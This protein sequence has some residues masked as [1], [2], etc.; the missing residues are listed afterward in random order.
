MKTPPFILAVSCAVFCSHALAQ[1]KPKQP[2]NYGLAQARESVGKMKV[3]DGLSVGLFAAEPMVQNPTA[4][5]IDSRGRV[6]LTEAANYR[7]HANPPIRPEGDRVMTLEDTNGDGEADK[8]TVFY[9][10]PSIN[11]ALGIAVL[12]NDV[13]VSVAP[14]VFVL[15]DTDGD[16]VA[17]QRLL[18]LTGTAGAQHDHSFHSFVHGTD[19]KLYFNFGNTGQH[20]RQ[21]AGKLLKVPL[22]GVI[23]PADVKD[24][25]APIIDLAGN[26]LE[27]SRKP[28]QQ[29]MVFRA[30]YA[31]GRLSN[32]EVLGYNFRNNYEAAPDSFGNL[33]QSDNDDDGNRGVRINYVMEH[34]SYGYSDELTGAAWQTKRPNIEKEIPLRHWHQNDPGTVPNLLQTGA[35]SPTGLLCNEGSALGAKFTNQIIHCDAGPRVVRAYPVQKAGAGFSAE[36][37]DILTSSDNWFRPSDVAIHPDG[38]LFVADWYDAGVGGH[39]M[40]DNEAPFLRGRIYRVSAKTGG[41]SV[42]KLDL[43]SAVGAV[44]ALQSPN[45]ATQFVAYRALSALGDA[46]LPA[47]QTLAE[48]G[49]PRLRAR[50]LA[51]LARSPKA[52]LPAL[53]AALTDANPDIVITAIRLATMLATAG[54]LDTSTLEAT[55]GLI[56]RLIGHKDPQVR[57]QLA[58]SLFHSK[59]VEPMWAKLAAQHDGSDRWYLE[60]LG[61]GARG[62]DDSCFDAWF[63]EVK[64]NW[65]TPGGRDILWR[66]RTPKTAPYLASLLLANPTE[67]RY[68]RAFDFIPESQ[69]RSDALLSLVK[70]NPGLAIVSEALQRLS[71]SGAKD[72]PRVRTATDAAL[73]RAKGRPEF[74][75]LVEAAGLGSWGGALLETA[76]ELGKAPEALD[77]VRLLVREGAGASQIQEALAKGDPARSAALVELLGSLGQGKA[78]EML[79]AELLQSKSAERGTLAI[80]A[81]A[82]TQNGAERLVKLAKEKRFPAELQSVA[83]SALAQVQYAALRE[84]IGLHFPPPGALGGAALPPVAELAKLS[85]D[86]ARGKGVFERASSSCVVCHKIGERGVD[87]G[88]ALG[89]I[90]GKLPKEAIF[91]AILNPN[92]GISMGFETAEVKLRGGGQALGIVRSDTSEEL[93]LAL[94]G[95][96]LQ[97]FAK[98]DVQR[99]SKLPT[100]LMP[101]GLNQALTREDLVDLVAYL[102]N[103]KAGSPK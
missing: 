89:E 70:A 61:I 15:R 68:M 23:D 77:A 13:I 28:Y 41:L 1:E 42:P 57:R 59:Q 36:M 40:A 86:F 74:V 39:A 53:Q 29:G 10:D 12:G 7:R 24:H 27:A 2:E 98:T 97:K 102:S 56:G 73:A 99:V 85:G 43:S 49:E 48:K 30:D 88:P 96:A 22:H 32:F 38:S 103:L 100:S 91:D 8:A 101:S 37:A 33:W 14:N 34:G 78:L 60:A 65:N 6:W 4:L 18:L 83:G 71:R 3:A 76:L 31:D 64:G 63:A 25:S 50:A 81:L 93:V 20:F 58:V 5:D 72:D 92:A 90:G 62:I 55:P 44:A 26:V 46:A 17:D 21:P 69:E 47:L 67:L 45:K 82:R 80:R 51:L 54:Q 9:Q 94:P 79:Q 16:G 95:G 66:L 35:G 52:A 75:E 87:F 84:E 19:G 11:S